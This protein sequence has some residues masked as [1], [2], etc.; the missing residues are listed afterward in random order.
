M[1]PILI[2]DV[3]FSLRQASS[4]FAI[5]WAA[6]MVFFGGYLKLVQVDDPVTIIVDVGTVTLPLVAC[7]VSRNGSLFS[8]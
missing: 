6:G 8:V 2:R 5:A 1:N 7:L 3:K 4:L